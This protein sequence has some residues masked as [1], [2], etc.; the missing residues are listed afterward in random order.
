MNPSEHEVTASRKQIA[1][2]LLYT[3]L[4]LV[5]FEIL[6]TI[7][8][9]TVIFQYIYLLVARRYSNPLRTF[10]NRVTTYAYKVMRYLT[11]NE[12]GRPFPFQEFPPEME[13]PEE[14]VTFS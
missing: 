13:R 8:Q 12:N 9:I 10:A 5:I 7:I 14:E 3:L 2:R 4:Y 1:I 6:K 11:L